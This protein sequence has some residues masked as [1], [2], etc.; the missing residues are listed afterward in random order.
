VSADQT[1]IA[2][3]A[4]TPRQAFE[5]TVTLAPPLP[6]HKRFSAH[7]VVVDRQQAVA[8]PTSNNPTLWN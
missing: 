7:R 3:D 2:T 4:A 1:L 6:A 5:E 8:S